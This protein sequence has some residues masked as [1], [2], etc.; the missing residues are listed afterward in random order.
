[1]ERKVISWGLSP[2]E[3]G[4]DMYTHEEYL[5]ELRHGNLDNLYQEGCLSIEDVRLAY[6]RGWITEDTAL[7][8]AEV[9]LN[10]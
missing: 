6:R 10:C 5:D 4:K 7:S 2:Q 9:L 8:W 1:M 3:R